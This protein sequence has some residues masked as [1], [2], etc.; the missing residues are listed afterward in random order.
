MLCKA[1]YTSV[2]VLF[3]V[4]SGQCAGGLASADANTGIT[5]KILL[6]QWS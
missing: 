1:Y 6:Q 4:V 5:T 3:R 2:P